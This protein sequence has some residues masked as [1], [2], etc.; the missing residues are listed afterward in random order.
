MGNGTEGS[1]VTRVGGAGLSKEV[2]FLMKY[3]WA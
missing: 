1:Y 2:T 3:D